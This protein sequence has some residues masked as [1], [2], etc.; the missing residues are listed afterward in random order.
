[1]RFFFENVFIQNF[2]N[3]LNPC[4]ISKYTQFIVALSISILRISTI[5]SYTSM[6]LSELLE[7][8]MNDTVSSLFASIVFI[9]Y[10]I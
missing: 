7:Y 6:V 1:M 3:P 9:R 2:T 4:K 8:I 10:R 5:P